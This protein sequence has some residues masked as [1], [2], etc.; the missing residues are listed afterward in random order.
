M[1]YMTVVPTEEL[2]VAQFLNNHFQRYPHGV[3]AIKV[4]LNKGI[5]VSDEKL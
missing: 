1:I 2:S 3:H 5:F 4:A